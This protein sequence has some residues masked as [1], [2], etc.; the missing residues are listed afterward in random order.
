M[1]KIGLAFLATAAL[2]LVASTGAEARGF[3]GFHGGGAFVAGSAAV[4]SA[5]ARRAQALVAPVSARACGAAVGAQR[6]SGRARSPAAC[7][8]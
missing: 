3:G 7:W 2:A 1:K 6:L 4:V 8:A 5:F